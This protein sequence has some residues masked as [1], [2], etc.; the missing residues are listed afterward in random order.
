MGKKKDLTDG[1][2]PGFSDE[3]LKQFLRYPMELDK[4]WWVITP[5]EQKVLDL[6][7]RLTVGF[8]KK[9]AYISLSQFVIGTKLHRGVGISRSTAR[10]AVRELARKGFIR[11]KIGAS[12]MTYISLKFTNESDKEQSSEAKRLIKLFQD[13]NP[14]RVE[15]MLNDYKEVRAAEELIKA[16]HFEKLEEIVSLVLPITNDEEFYPTITSPSELLEKMARLELM[17]RRQQFTLGHYYQ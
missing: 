13:V 2:F 14:A 12:S 3:Y 16:I 15:A 10:R 1:V 11:T 6:I 17:M 9:G 7:L 5:S 4:W 8:R